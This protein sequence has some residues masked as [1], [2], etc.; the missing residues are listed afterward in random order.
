[1]GLHARVSYLSF[2]LWCTSETHWAPSI[3]MRIQDLFCGSDMLWR[4][5]LILVVQPK[6]V[7]ACCFYLIDFTGTQGFWLFFDQDHSGMDWL[8]SIIPLD[9]QVGEISLEPVCRKSDN[10]SLVSSQDCD[11]LAWKQTTN[12]FLHL[13]ISSSIGQD[14]W[15][16]RRELFASVF[17]LYSAQSHSSGCSD[18]TSCEQFVYLVSETRVGWESLQETHIRENSV[19]FEVNTNWSWEW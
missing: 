2:E 14:C 4:D 18:L 16:P 11:R 17:P 19:E 15:S 1:M 8:L 3:S 9:D 5:S 12:P 10:R 6:L 7:T 13:F